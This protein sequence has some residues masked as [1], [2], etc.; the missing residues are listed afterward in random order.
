[1]NISYQSI[2]IKLDQICLIFFDFTLV[3][4]KFKAHFS[5][6]Q[7]KNLRFLHW[8]YI[9]N[10][11]IHIISSDFANFKILFIHQINFIFIY[12]FFLIFIFNFIFKLHFH[13]QY[14]FR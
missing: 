5:F 8:L 14:I 7:F 6:I 10:F 4:F 3:K 12:L 9:F 13:H 11:Q 1:L 2:Y